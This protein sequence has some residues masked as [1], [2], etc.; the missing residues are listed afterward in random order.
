V[1][2]HGTLNAVVLPAV[3]RFNESHVGDK[4]KRLRQVMGLS[5]DD[6]LAEAVAGLNARLGLPAGL[7]EMGL[8]ERLIPDLAAA[9]TKDHCAETNPRQASASDYEALFR[10]AMG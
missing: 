1:L 9:A 3:L 6:G 7:A 8:P 4:Y 10:E 5:E 2:H